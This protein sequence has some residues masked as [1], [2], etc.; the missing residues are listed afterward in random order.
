MQ[1]KK[2]ENQKDKESQTNMWQEI[3]REAMTK[4]EV[5]DANLFVMGGQKSGKKSL[6][7]LM[8]KQVAAKHPEEKQKLLVIEE[9]SSKYG[10]IDYNFLPVVNLQESDSESMG[11]MGVWILNEAIQ[12]EGFKTLLETLIKPQDIVKCA[13][14]IVVDLSK[15]FEIMKWLNNWTKFIYD[16][17]SKLLLKFDY[18]KQSKIKTNLENVFKLYEEP[19]FDDEGNLK[20]EILSEEAKTVKLEAP[21]K[22]GVLKSNCGVPI[23]FVVN[24]SDALSEA[25]DKY[26]IEQQSEFILKHVRQL[27]VE[28]GA[29]IIYTSGKRNINIELLYNYICHRLFDFPLTKKPNL[30]EKDSYF[31]PAGYDSLT[32]LR[33]SDSNQDLKKFFEDEIKEEK[34]NERKKEETEVECEDTNNFLKN[35]KADPTMHSKTNIPM[36]RTTPINQSEKFKKLAEQRKPSVQGNLEPNKMSNVIIFFNFQLTEA[37]HPQPSVSESM[38]SNLQNLPRRSGAGLP[39]AQ[40][41][42]GATDA[43]HTQTKLEM[44]KKLKALRDKK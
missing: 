43:K 11:E 29:S 25:D 14:V 40:P 5:E 19:Q 2:S 17:F 39:E 28:F 3:L 12:N 4:K 13:C 38:A 22:E 21:L 23:I 20:K 6:I 24:K 8:E 1:D 35:L 18:E 33:E 10:I 31:I 7:K 16:N 15:R 32:M 44:I 41:A 26:L 9:A 30:I 42:G 27:A 36:E 37:A 34:K